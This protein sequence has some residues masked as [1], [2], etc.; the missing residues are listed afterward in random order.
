MGSSL[1]MSSIRGTSL[2]KLFKVSPNPV[3]YVSSPLILSKKGGYVAVWVDPSVFK[4]RFEACKYS[5]IGRVVLSYGKGY[6]QIILNLDVDK[7]MVWSLGSLSLKPVVLLLQPWIPFNPALQKSS[8]AQVWVHFYD[9]SWEYWH[10]KIVSDLPRGI[11]VP[12]RLDMATLE[13]DFGYLTHVLMDIDVSIVPSSSLFLERDDSQSSFISVE[14]ENLTALCSTC[15]SIG[16]LPNAFRWN[17]SDK[18]ILVSSSSDPVLSMGTFTSIVD[19]PSV[20][21]LVGLTISVVVAQ[22]SMSVDVILIV[23][24]S[25][26]IVSI[27]IVLVV[28]DSPMDIGSDLSLDLSVGQASSFLGSET[29]LES[30]ST[31]GLIFDGHFTILK[32]TLLVIDSLVQTVPTIMR[33]F[34]LQ[35]PSLLYAAHEADEDKVQDADFFTFPLI[36]VLYWNCHGAHESLGLH[37]LARSSCEDFKSVIED[38]DLIG[39]HSQGACFT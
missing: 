8:N 30:S 18:G 11:R 2:K 22:Q 37:S 23:P 36:S 24:R 32:Q 15:S 14:Y 6:F 28:H 25:L 16:H 27:S 29:I 33:P 12:L 21:S 34:S 7:N 1:P 31:S 5:L 39:V 26:T 17:K 13:G 10:L 35:R 4:S 9:L 3:D 19:S 20:T 38:C